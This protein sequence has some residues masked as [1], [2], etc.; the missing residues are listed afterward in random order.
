MLKV[1]QIYVIRD[2]VIREGKSQRQAAREVGCSRNTVRRCLANLQTKPGSPRPKVQRPSPVSD[3]AESQIEQILAE[4][5]GRT[6]QKQRVTGSRLH[7]ELLSRGIQVGVTTVR[8]ILRE[9]K[10]RQAEVYI[11]LV[12]RP[13]DEAQVDFFEVTV[14][15][16]GERRKLWMFLMRL[17]YSKRDFAW[18]YE[19]CDQLAFLDGHVRAFAHFR[20][21]PHRCV[22]DNLRPAMKKVVL[23]RRELTKSF[24]ALLKHYLFEPCFAR[25]ARGDDKGGVEARGKGVRLQHMTPIPKGETRDDICQR[26]VAQLDARAQQTKLSDGRTI[27]DRFVEE[28]CLMLPAAH[29][30]Q[31]QR[32]H[33]VSVD[34]T[35][36]VQVEGA[37]YSLP[38]A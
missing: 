22:Y 23:P 6:T 28:H 9:I 34:K 19:R 31:A 8:R 18:L 36:M 26:L 37:R 3:Q 15:I 12:H 35:S 38:S 16:A 24:A 7:T 32:T 1:D 25:V 29:P 4:W 14:D 17:M 5:E 13:G 2:K 11:P 27:R 10:R 20:G 30:Y 33:L 21:V